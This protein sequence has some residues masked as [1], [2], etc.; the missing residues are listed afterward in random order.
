MNQGSIIVCVPVGLTKIFKYSYDAGKT[1][2]EEE[3]LDQTASVNWIYN[4]PDSSKLSVVIESLDEDEII[5][6]YVNLKQLS[7]PT[8]ASNQYERWIPTDAESSQLCVLGRKKTYLRVAKETPCFSDLTEFVVKVENC[9]CGTADY[10]C[11]FNYFYNFSSKI[12]V[13][14]PGVSDTIEC[15]DGYYDRDQHMRKVPGNTCDKSLEGSVDYESKVKTKCPDLVVDYF[16]KTQALA[17][18]LGIG[19]TFAF[20]LIAAA[21]VFVVWSRRKGYLHYRPVHTQDMGIGPDEPTPFDN[22]QDPDNS[23]TK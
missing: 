15:V 19:L 21:V 8:C 17:I 1:W 2:S 11:N 10:G 3:F 12:C 18:G 14:E 20:L 16:Q 23:E 6:S 5:Y 13:P 4:E 7:L 22:I 9:P